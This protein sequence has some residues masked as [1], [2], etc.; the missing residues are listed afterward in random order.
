MQVAVLSD[1]HSNKVA[2]DAV[3]DD[4]AGDSGV[5]PDAMVCAGDVVGY[6]PWPAEC[7]A[8]VR[9]REIPTVMGNHDRAVASDTTFRFNSMAAAGVEH[10]REALDDDALGWLAGLPDSRTVLDGR[11]KLVHGH[12][13]DPDRYTYPEEFSASMLGDEDVLVTGHTHVQ[14]HRLF[15]EGVVMNPGSVGQPRDSDPRAA[16]ALVDLEDLTVD[17]RR[18]EYDV[19]S[20][21]EAVQ[22]AGLPERIGS[23]LYEGR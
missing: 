7:V 14:G 2:L 5:K 17:E 22:E 1:I 16:Y 21:V 20:V 23:R 13:D 10:A 9:E 8:A 11:L 12:P 18:V 6:N 15:D 3:L 4:L 19:D